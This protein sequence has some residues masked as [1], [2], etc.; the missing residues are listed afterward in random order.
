MQ[1][2]ITGH[3]V[4]LTDPLKQYVKEK[5]GRVEQYFDN[6]IDGHVVLRHEKIRNHAEVNLNVAG[7]VLHAS[8]E[9]K[10]MYA[11]IDE[12]ADKLERQVVKYKE[13]L[14]NTHIG[15]SKRQLFEKA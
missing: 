14:N 11:A 4:E 10:D 1:I 5:L 2:S 13:K 3:H 6:V 12:L 15:A 7:A 9:D 8:T